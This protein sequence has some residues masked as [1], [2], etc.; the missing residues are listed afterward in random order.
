ME[1][2]QPVR[3]YFE[4]RNAFDVSS[5]LDQFEDSAVVQRRRPGISRPQLD[6]EH[7]LRKPRGC[8]R[9]RST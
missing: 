1:L 2:S 5:A 9:L 8:I 4:S 7:G 6:Q 3:Q